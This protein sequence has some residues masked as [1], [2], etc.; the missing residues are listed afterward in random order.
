MFMNAIGQ[1]QAGNFPVNDRQGMRHAIEYLGLDMRDLATTSPH[2]P[3]MMMISAIMSSLC[4]AEYWFQK[5]AAIRV[6]L[7]VKDVD[8]LQIQEPRGVRVRE[9]REPRFGGEEAS[10]HHR[11][12][13]YASQE[14]TRPARSPREV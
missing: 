14:E 2:H 11:R 4:D 5:Y 6:W 10:Y 12:M 13:A 8:V 1:L 9:G 7:S 3:K